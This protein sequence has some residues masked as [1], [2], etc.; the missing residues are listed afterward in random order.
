MLKNYFKIAWRNLV[1][2]KLFSFINLT[3][4]SIGTAVVILIMLFVKNEWSYDQFHTH[5]DR[6]YRTWVKEHFKDQLIFNTVTPLMLGSELT[7][8]FPEIQAATRYMNAN[9]L[10]KRASFVEEEVVHYVDPDFFKIFE[11]SLI[12]GKKDKVLSNLHQAVITEEI[13]QKYFGDITPVG[14]TL[15]MQVGG[16]WTDFLISG[17]IEEAPNNSS[18]QYQILIPFES[19]I[20]LSGSNANECWTCVYGE[21]YVLIDPK[22]NVEDLAAKI[23]PFIDEKVKEDY[24][25]GKYIIGL[26]A[27]N[28]IHLNNDIPV[29]VV[30]VSDARYPYILASVA[31]LI[32]LLA[33]IN[34]MTLSVGRSMRR[35]KEVGVRKVTGATKWQLRTQFWSEAIL[36]AMI[37]LVL[38]V[39]LARI[40]LPFFNVLADKQMVLDINLSNLSFFIGLALLIGILSGIYPSLVL[41]RFSPIQAIKGVLVSSGN[42]RH[43]VLKWLVGFQFVLSV[44]LIICTFGMQKQMHYLQNKN[45]GFSGEQTIVVPFVSSGQRLSDTW[46]SAL[47]VQERLKNE[48]LGKGVREVLT[49]SHTFGTQGWLQVGYTDKE[50]NKFRQFNTQQIDFD[51]LDA[52][53]IELT[54]GRNFLKESG[55]DKKA[56]I[57][58]ESFAKAWQLDNPVGAYL[59]KPFMDYQIIGVAKDFHFGSLHTPIDPLV[60]VTDFIPLFQAAP[61]LNW[62]DTPDPKFSFKVD[63]ENLTATLG[64]IQRAWK[65][66]TTEKA[67]NYTFLDENIKRQYL[68]ETKLSQIF[69]LATILAILIACLG[70]FGI[71][72]LAIA[73]RAKEIG[74]R[75]ILGASTLNIV[76]LLNKN[77]TILVIAATIIAT[78]IARYFMNQWLEDFAYRT[79]IQWWVFLL[80][81]L[82]AVGIAFLTVS[83]QS[84]KAAITNPV[85]SIKSE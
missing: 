50:T 37:A 84:L 38:G 81:G 44:F 33:C 70:L 14:Q 36:T 72:T 23:A 40:F 13:G 79:D 68:S 76:F 20:A 65:N 69:N 11:F 53:Q 46:Q 78:P 17:I 71:A 1:K 8:N 29:G 61:D 62:L 59:P 18:I 4:L 77:F 39:L 43:L 64:N 66:A 48:L 57:I 51:Y 10:V 74:I 49:S 73:N 6:I 25:A 32:L 42:D 12:K 45:L 75:K 9:S 47:Q 35:A 19:I 67:F 31:L 24:S 56:A 15:S 82:S 16:E 26:Q 30:P 27:L 34:F 28:D 63:G 7:N 2:D 52:M 55:T 85:N 3:G 80:A 83:F 58:N 21:T 41:S 5:S 60:M 54:D 22:S